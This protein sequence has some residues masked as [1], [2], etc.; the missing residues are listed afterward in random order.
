M[1]FL[2]IFAVGKGLVGK[3]RIGYGGGKFLFFFAVGYR[4]LSLSR[5]Q[6]SP[7][8]LV[9]CCCYPFWKIVGV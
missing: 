9:L 7:N 2:F 6:L 1:L 8:F 4:F 5:S 3:W